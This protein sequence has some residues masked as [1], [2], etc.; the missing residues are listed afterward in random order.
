MLFDWLVVEQAMPTNPAQPVRGPKHS[1]RKGKT[2]VLQTEEARQL[3][4]SIP[5]NTAM[6]LRDRAL[7][8]LMVYS[9]ARA[10]AALKMRVEDYFIQG[11]K[12]YRATQRLQESESAY[13]EALQIRR[14]ITE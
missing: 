13:Q 3:L 7:I 9:F 11:R 14:E 5:E 12:G 2:P 4:D 6:D 1:A 10:G 8:A